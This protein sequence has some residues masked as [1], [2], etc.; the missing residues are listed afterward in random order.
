M[1]M[2]GIARIVL[3]SVLAASPVYEAAAQINIR[4]TPP[5]IVTAENESW[6]LSGTPITYWG[7]I[8]YQAGPRIHFIATEMIRSG[9]FRG[10]PLYTR[11]TIEPFSVVFLP[12]GH[13]LLQPYERRRVG[14]LAGTTGSSAPSFPTAIGTDWG[15]E[16]DFGPQAPAPPR[17]GSDWPCEPCYRPVGTSGESGAG[18]SEE[19]VDIDFADP[20]RI[21]N[22][23]TAQRAAR[24]PDSVN[25]IFVTY[26]NQRWF[27]SGP[28]VPFDA[29]EFV[30]TGDQDGL[31]IYRSR[32][33]SQSTIYIPV[34]KEQTDTLAPYSKRKR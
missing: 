19:P 21:V 6:Y 10:I 24:R 4:T 15:S 8:Y 13:G 23:A 9:D 28:P 25:G 32:H 29:S 2:K 20:A 7:Y 16:Y 17:L 33:G 22:L 11:T 27:S 18:Y 31:P 14:Q 1:R 30:R 3:C 26:Q 12:V 5:P 34:L